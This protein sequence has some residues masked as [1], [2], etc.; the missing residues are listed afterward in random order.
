MCLRGR[1]RQYLDDLKSRGDSAGFLTHLVWPIKTCKT[2][3][4]LINK[5]PSFF[6]CFTRLRLL[7]ASKFLI[8][9]QCFTY[10]YT[11]KN[12]NDCEGFLK[13]QMS[14]IR[15]EILQTVSTNLAG[16]Q[17]GY[18]LICSEKVV[19][20]ERMDLAA[21]ETKQLTLGAQ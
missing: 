17:K 20:A 1:E 6:C 16:I 13:T 12:T 4:A 15:S 10:C 9:F 14:P 21:L 19:G 5:F 18:D 7:D 2:V 3:K 11:F 8:K